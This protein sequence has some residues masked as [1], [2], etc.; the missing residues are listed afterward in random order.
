MP[1]FCFPYIRLARAGIEK[2]TSLLVT[3]FAENNPQSVILGY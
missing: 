1:A 3:C 2:P